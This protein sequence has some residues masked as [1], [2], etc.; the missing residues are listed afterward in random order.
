MNNENN[1]SGVPQPGPQPSTQPPRP[2]PLTQPLQPQSQPLT[3]PPKPQPLSSSQPFQPASPQL[4]PQQGTQFPSK[5]TTP[6]PFQTAQPSQSTTPPMG[7]N[8]FGPK[9]RSNITLIAI[10]AVVLIAAIVAVVVFV[11]MPQNQG[12]GSG[13]SS[14]SSSSS[15]SSNSS[16]SS[17]DNGNNNQSNNS[18]A[19]EPNSV[20]LSPSDLRN[21]CERHNLIYSESNESDI[22]TEI[23]CSP[24]ASDV[25]NASLMI[26]YGLFDES[27]RNDIL[28]LIK[29]IFSGSVM[30]ED[31]DNYTKLYSPGDVSSSIL[32]Y[33]YAIID[34]DNC[35]IIAGDSEAAARNALL[36]MGYP[37]RNWP[38]AEEIERES[39]SDS[40]TEA[41]QRD[42]MRR[43]DIS[44]IDTSLIQYQ[45]NNPNSR[46]PSGPSYWDGSLSLE[47]GDNVAC[48]FVKNYL[49]NYSSSSTNSFVDPDGTP[50]G[51]YITENWSSNG[52]ISPTFGNEFSYLVP[53]ESGDSYTIGGSS[54][55][56]QHIMYIIPGA[57]C[58][59]GATG[60]VQSTQR[61]F[62]IM[63][64]LENGAT[65]C[66]DDQ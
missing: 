24:A 45:T 35:I 65:Y 7:A 34:K 39:S 20:S 33:G 16:N 62:A 25:E 59:I 49:N 27:K 8:N 5:A 12:G 4:P 13:R 38:S 52:S 2:Q 23:V 51:V 1:F 30:L 15:N 21:F 50:Y 6:F 3:Q 53:S 31:T 19:D 32:T 17:D 28:L 41:A 58:Q 64:I 9:K 26:E 14:G 22:G 47:C 46:L 29:S 11:F 57:M 36:E 18:T 10:L 55:F 37:D 48:S 42:V 44:R 66:M 54:S 61:H 40:S 43:N 56:S 60:V 63:Y